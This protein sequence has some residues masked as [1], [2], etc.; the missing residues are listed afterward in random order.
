VRSE[1][2]HTLTKNNTAGKQIGSSPRR[3]E[4]RG[5]LLITAA[6]VSTARPRLRPK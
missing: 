5:E 1:K 4:C 3:P 2:Q 6:V